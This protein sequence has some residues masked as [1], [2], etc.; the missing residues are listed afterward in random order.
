MATNINTRA[1]TNNAMRKAILE[2]THKRLLRTLQDR[3]AILIE[4]LADR[5]DRLKSQVDR[6]IAVQCLDRESRLMHDIEWALD[7]LPTN[8]YGICESCENSISSTRLDALPWARVCFVC[9]S[10]T[11]AAGRVREPHVQRA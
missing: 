3:E 5:A 1:T 11:E 7:K 9:Q 10:K 2:Q 6:E 4:T 8:A